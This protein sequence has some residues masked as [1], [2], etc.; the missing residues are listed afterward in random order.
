MGRRR[1]VGQFRALPGVGVP[2]RAGQDAGDLRP[3][4][5]PEHGVV[6]RPGGRR[7]EEARFLPR[8]RVPHQGRGPRPSLPP[9]PAR[10]EPLP[11]LRLRCQPPPRDGD[12]EDPEPRGE[13]E[14]GE[15]RRAEDPRDRRLPAC[16]G[17]VR[18]GAGVEEGAPVEHGAPP[19]V[20][21]PA[22]ARPQGLQDLLPVFRRVGHVEGPGCGGGHHGE[23]RGDRHGAAGLGGGGG[24]EPREE[25]PAG[26]GEDEPEHRPRGE[27]PRE[28]GDEDSPG[29]QLQHHGEGDAGKVEDLPEAHAPEEGDHREGEERRQGPGED[30]HGA[31][32]DLGRREAPGA[33]GGGEDEEER[34]ALALLE[35]GPDDGGGREDGERAEKGEG[36]SPEQLPGRLVRG[37]GEE[38]QVLAQHDEDDGRH[39]DG[40]GRAEGEGPRPHRLGEEVPLEDGPHDGFP[41]RSR[42]S[43]TL[44]TAS[45]MWSRPGERVAGRGPDSPS[46]DRRAIS[47]SRTSGSLSQR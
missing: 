15:G 44:R 16:G 35:H 6:E 9:Q 40:H 13:E 1:R 23:P 12:R 36:P 27:L 41:F 47:R 21:R 39:G 7:V 46:S 10:V 25:H 34:L 4:H 38:P 33:D 43:R 20:D 19:V 45:A 2:S 30:R 32:E 8:H 37:V 28:G 11:W 17:V 14:V 5:D 29:G 42:S 24:A 31:R 26:V 3:G 18:G 22:A